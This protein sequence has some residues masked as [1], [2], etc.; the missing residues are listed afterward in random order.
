M[1]YYLHDTGKGQ[2]ASVSIFKD[3]AGTDESVH[4]TAEYVKEHLSKFIT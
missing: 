3:K 4:L 2:A 1:R